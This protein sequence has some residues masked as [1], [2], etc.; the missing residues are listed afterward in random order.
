MTALHPAPSVTPL[1]R[2]SVISNY[3]QVLQ[4]LQTD[5]VVTDAQLSR[6]GLDG[7]R[8]PALTLSVQPLVD[9]TIEYAVT[10][11]IL[12][13]QIALQ[14]PGD[15]THLAGLA[16]LRAVLQQSAEGW[17]LMGSASEIRPDAVLHEQGRRIAVEYDAGYR[18]QVVRR[19]MAAF[20]EYDAVIWG[21]PSRLRSQRLQA[22]YPHVRVLTVDYW[23][24]AHT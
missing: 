18:T 2:R 24:A 23:T 1:E 5:R 22:E 21:T 11:R 10:F 9:S 3:H 6:L 12:S 19:K 4:L 7:R 15:L 17:E 20:A 16:Q 14:R 13:T 8:F